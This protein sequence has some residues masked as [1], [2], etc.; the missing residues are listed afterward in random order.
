M[1]QVSRQIK[2]NAP[3]EKV[4]EVLADFGGVSNWAPTVVSAYSTTEANGGV[5]AGRHCEVKGFG[6]IEER[7][8][9]WDEGHSYSYDVVD[10]VPA[11]MKYIRNTVSVRPDG[12]GTLVR[13]ALEFQMKFGPL[14]ALLERLA[15]RPQMRKTLAVSL[16]GLKHHAETGEVI[17]EDTELPASALAAVA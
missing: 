10:G 14:G 3:K 12:D 7:I 1:T 4:W 5:G 13:F 15:I 9:E 6:S 8:P 16:A 11:P 17:G 2:I